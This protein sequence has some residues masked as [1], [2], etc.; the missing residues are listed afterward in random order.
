MSTSKKILE[1]IECLR[2]DN[3]F[4]NHLFKQN[5]VLMRRIFNPLSRDNEVK[6]IALE[7]GQYL[8]TMN[9]SCFDYEKKLY[10]TNTGLAPDM[11]VETLEQIYKRMMETKI[12]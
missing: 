4:S 1:E 10:K 5:Q 6:E 8:M 3:D 2:K 12:R 11:L 9:V 7:F